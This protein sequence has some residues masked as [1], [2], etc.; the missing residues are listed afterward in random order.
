MS[1]ELITTISPATNAPIITRNGLGDSD[2]ALLPATATQAFNDYR[3]T[4]LQQ[5]KSIVT[6]ALQLLKDRQHVLAKELAKQMGR[7]ITYGTKEITTAV[8]RGEYM[9]K[10]SEDALEDT[11]GEPEN[12]FKRYIRKLPVGPVLIMFAWNVSHPQLMTS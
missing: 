10:I 11:Q 12:G 9:L 5:R 3:L 8:A 6:K 1:T 7:P 4:S 2:I